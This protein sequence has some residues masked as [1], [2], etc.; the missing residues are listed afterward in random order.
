MKRRLTTPVALCVFVCVLCWFFPLFHVRPLGIGAASAESNH[1]R[2]A[3]SEK[4]PQSIKDF[5]SG[6]P[7]IEFWQAFDADA[8]K[9]QKQ[10]GRQAGLGGAWYFCVEGTGTV[11][12]KDKERVL[13]KI[14]G[15][16]RHV[17]LD[18]SVLVDNTVREAVGV[19]ASQ[20]ANSQDF[21]AFAAQLNQQVEQEVIAPNRDLLSSGNFVRFVGCFKYSS[22]SDLD[23]LTLIP[24]HLEVQS[25]KDKAEGR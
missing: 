17:R 20:F 1:A 24:I 5:K 15:S 14:D 3:A 6:T 4:Q 10:Y 11:E 23:P 16:P 22:K 12:S 2:Q 13:L 19:K 25:S 7:V 21:N 18:L 9:A 8:A